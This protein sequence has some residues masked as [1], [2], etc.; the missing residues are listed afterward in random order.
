MYYYIERKVGLRCLK[1]LEEWAGQMSEGQ[2]NETAQENLGCG[3]TVPAPMPPRVTYLH[4][5]LTVARLLPV[6][7]VKLKTD[8]QTRPGRFLGARGRCT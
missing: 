3:D 8:L 5:M 4:Q 1:G 7:A 6:L 2:R